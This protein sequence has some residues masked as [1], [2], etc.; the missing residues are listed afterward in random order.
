MAT[1]STCLPVND[2]IFGPAVSGCRDDFDFTL[3]FE[4]SILSIGPSALLLLITPLRIL[5]LARR[6]VK[7]VPSPID[8]AK[9][10]S[11]IVPPK[12]E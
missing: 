2:Q 7:T 12:N 1:N 6:N 9:L 4:Q 10:V 5:H 11:D 8:A 3:L